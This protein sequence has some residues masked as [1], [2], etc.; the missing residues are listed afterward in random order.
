MAHGVD[1][2]G[3]GARRWRATPDARAAF[4]V[5]PTYYGMAADVAGCAEVAH[6]AGVPLVVDQSWGPHFGFHAGLPPE[7][8]GPR[9]PTPCSPRRTR[10]PGR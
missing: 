1:A 9:A 7:R 10:S 5:S 6:A 2:R 3:A 4:I 8:A